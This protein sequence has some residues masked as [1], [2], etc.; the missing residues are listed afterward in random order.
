M[1]SERKTLPS[2]EEALTTALAQYLCPLDG[3]E[4]E[5]LQS[6]DPTKF[7][8]LYP[9]KDIRADK[10]GLHYK[11][12]KV[13]GFAKP[14]PEATAT[15]LNNT[16]SYSWYAYYGLASGSYVDDTVLDFLHRHLMHFIPKELQEGVRFCNVVATGALGNNK[17]LGRRGSGFSP[18]DSG[19]DNTY[20]CLFGKEKKLMEWKRIFMPLHV[21]DNHFVGAIIHPSDSRVSTF[22]HY[23]TDEASHQQVFQWLTAMLNH[24][25]AHDGLS[26]TKWKHDKIEVPEQTD[27]CSCGLLRT[28]NGIVLTLPDDQATVKD[29]LVRQ[30][31]I[32]K[33]IRPKLT[34]NI[35]LLNRV[36][37]DPDDLTRHF[38]HAGEQ[39]EEEKKCELE[40]KKDST[41]GDN[42][43]TTTKEVVPDA[44]LRKL[45]QPKIP[46]EV[47]A[48][49]EKKCREMLVE[50]HGHLFRTLSHTPPDNFIESCFDDEHDNTPQQQRDQV[51]KCKDDFHKFVLQYNNHCVQVLCLE[52]MSKEI[53]CEFEATNDACM[54]V[55]AEYFAETLAHTARATL[56]LDNGKAIVEK[57][58]GRTLHCTDWLRDTNQNQQFV[59]KYSFIKMDRVLK[60]TEDDAQWYETL[61]GWTHEMYDTITN[62]RNVYD[63]VLC[64]M[65]RGMSAERSNDRVVVSYSTFTGVQ[66]TVVRF[67]SIV[68]RY[69]DEYKSSESSFPL[70]LDFFA[71]RF[72]QLKKLYLECIRANVPVPER[73]MKELVSMHSTVVTKMYID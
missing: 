18:A 12:Y 21:N 33:F 57:D 66:Q 62:I 7:S 69:S 36:T 54:R 8:S 30:D 14:T 11:H 67:I 24:A 29:I 73:L 38:T 2:V 68:P 9:Y 48:N 3:I 51:Q 37:R 10:N 19:K 65:P 53:W 59:T 13:D 55:F 1:D 17:R 47:P 15:F 58:I 70:D 72:Y 49:V 43:K 4:K 45:L 16:H 32:V 39:C 28:V 63:N 61:L 22:D 44:A 35:L 34:A 26:P 60:P 31:A 25:L 27:S 50:A 20:T 6:Y 5:A 41:K 42:T 52:S 40:K 23:G 64:N 71:Y 46:I 56:I